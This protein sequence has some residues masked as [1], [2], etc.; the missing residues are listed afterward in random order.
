MDNIT[1]ISMII[2]VMISEIDYIKLNTYIKKDSKEKVNW[3]IAFF[4]GKY[5]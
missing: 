1:Y 4:L 2:N 5:I 3:Q